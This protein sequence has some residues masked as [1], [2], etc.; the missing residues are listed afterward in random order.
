M[1]AST[2]RSEQQRSCIAIIRSATPLG[3]E[4]KFANQKKIQAIVGSAIQRANPHIQWKRN[5]DY[6]ERFAR[7]SRALKEQHFSE[8][9][10][11]AKR[12]KVDATGDT[13]KPPNV[14]QQPRQQDLTA[15]V[16]GLIPYGKLVKARNMADLEEELLFRHVPIEEIPKGITERKDMLKEMEDMRLTWEGVNPEDAVALKTFKKLSNAPFKLSD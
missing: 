15:A 2:D 16:S 3:K 14:Y 11:E 10:A 8:E 4:K 6:S 1:A 5:A 13:Y 9:R 7:V 12:A